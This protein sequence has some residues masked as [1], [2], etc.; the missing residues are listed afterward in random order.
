M[1]V[2]RVFEED[3]ILAFERYNRADNFSRKGLSYLYEYLEEISEGCKTPLEL[4]VIGLCCDFT[5]VKD[6]EE[7][8]RDYDPDCETLQDIIERYTVVVAESDC[9]LFHNV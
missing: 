1:I 5:E 4:D 7:F 8:K 9:I 3:F 2:E 6:L